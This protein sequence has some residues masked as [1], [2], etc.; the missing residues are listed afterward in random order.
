MRRYLHL[1]RVIGKTF[2]FWLRP[3]GAFTLLQVRQAISSTTSFIPA[4]GDR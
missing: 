1:Y 3:L 2:G 4:T